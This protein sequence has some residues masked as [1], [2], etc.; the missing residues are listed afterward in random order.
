MTKFKI[1]EG[2]KEDAIEKLVSKYPYD[3]DVIEK[4][5]GL[6][7]TL[8]TKVIPFIESEVQKEI[9]D[10]QYD[11]TDTW[12]T[13]VKN[14]LSKFIKNQER[15]TIDTLSS[16]KQL[17][18]SVEERTFPKL[19]KAMKAPKDINSYTLGSLG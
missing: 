12:V 3:K 19:D 10:P 18:D 5:F 17:W 16:A 1:F 2:K 15:I 4:A 11:D 6:V 8:G 7:S 9:V 13:S 14:K